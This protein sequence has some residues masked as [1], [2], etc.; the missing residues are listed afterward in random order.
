MDTVLNW[1]SCRFPYIAVR[2]NILLRDEA[3]MSYDEV[4]LVPDMYVLYIL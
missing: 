4:N 1:L 3:S 2:T